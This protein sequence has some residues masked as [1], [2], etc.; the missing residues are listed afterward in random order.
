MEKESLST[1]HRPQKGSR[2]MIGLVASILIAG[3]GSGA[4]LRHDFVQ[5]LKT[6][7][8]QA[9]AQKIGTDGFQAFAQTTCAGAEAPFKASLTSANVSHGMGKRESAADA[10]AQVKDYY[11]QWDGNYA[12]DAP[13]PAPAAAPTQ[14]AAV[15]KSDTPP[16][17]PQ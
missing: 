11:S 5:C 9:K 12:A 17:K 6:A 7:A 16:A 8:A 13:A 3:A 14:N 1:N 2:L 4:D 10:A 15:A